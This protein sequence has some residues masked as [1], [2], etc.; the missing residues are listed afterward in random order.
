[1]S[2]F[3]LL[4]FHQDAE[5][6]RSA[7][8]FTSA[9]TRFSARLIE[10][11]Y[12]CSLMLVDL[13]ALGD[14]S[15]AFKG[16]TCLSKVHA[17]FFRLSEDLDFGVSMPTTS[18]RT[19]RSRRIAPIREY[20]AA[21]PSRQPDL[22]IAD[23]L[24]GFNN[25][26]QYRGRIA[27]TSVITGQDDFIK[28]EISVREPI[29]EPI[30]LLDTRTMLLDPFRDLPAIPVF[31][32]PVLSLREAYAEKLRAALTRQV[33]V[34][35]DFFDLDHAISAGKVDIADSQLID[36]LR[37]KLGIPGNGPVDVSPRK[38]ERLRGQIET[39]L[40]PVLRE[41]DLERFNLDRAVEQV[42]RAARSATT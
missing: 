25:S 38:V 22:R 33:P 37:A 17:D 7:I 30:E 36:L 5:L 6:F 26:I 34:I 40:R 8:Q 12:Y 42:A 41:V 31:Q 9:E 14:F 2:D 23:R 18:S 15:L 10:K 20:L 29:V 19:K 16:G 11:D 24:R 32:T 4:T 13:R 3:P 27:Y 39:Q 1:M 35:R 21:I 28:I